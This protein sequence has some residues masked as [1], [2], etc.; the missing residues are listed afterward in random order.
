MKPD[1]TAMITAI[2][3]KCQTHRKLIRPKQTT[4]PD[5]LAV[6]KFNKLVRHFFNT[7]TSSVCAQIL[8]KF[9]FIL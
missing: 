1:I 8:T 4:L 7:V 9:T 6:Q 2:I 5:I 3:I